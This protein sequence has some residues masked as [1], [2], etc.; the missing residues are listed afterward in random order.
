E[1]E[2]RQ[3]GSGPSTVGKKSNLDEQAANAWDDSE[4]P[5]RLRVRLRNMIEQSG[6]KM[7]VK[8][9]IWNSV[10]VGAVVGLPVIISTQNGLIGL[11]AY[12]LA[13]AAPIVYVRMRQQQ[14]LA[15]LRAQLPDAF[16]LMGR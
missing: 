15:Q 14:R 12:L 13:A 8:R 11:A 7:T 3:A 6:L 5:T 10:G 9:L 16:D 1:A 2:L 4:D